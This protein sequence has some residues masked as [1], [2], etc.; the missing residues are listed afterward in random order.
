MHP[1]FKFDKLDA[2]TRN[3]MSTEINAARDTGALYF[4]QRFNEIGHEGW[5][6]WLL[7]ASQE[8]DE[9]WL[10]YQLENMGAMKH[11]ESRA[12]PKGGYTMAH[13]PDT[14]AETLADG[15]FNRY[16]IA[17]VCQRAAEDG[18]VTVTIHRAKDRWEPRAESI[19]LEGTQC[20]AKSLLL[21]V[22]SRELSLKCALLKPNSG[23]SITY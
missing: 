18:V 17:A 23:L 3:L 21:E 13:V 16:Y 4:S 5:P 15:Q 1:R 19:A 11:F 22:R 7:I 20:E 12:K 10:A 9:H 14:A 6:G 2:R 8:Y